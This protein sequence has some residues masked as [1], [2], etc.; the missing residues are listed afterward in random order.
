MTSVKDFGEP[1]FIFSDSTEFTFNPC[2]TGDTLVTVCDHGMIEDK[3][4]VSMGQIYQI[5]MKMLVDLYT[6]SDLPPMIV[7]YDTT[8]GKLEFDMLDAAA[9]TRKS[10]DVLELELED[11][12]KLKLT[13]DHKVW[14]ET[15]GW[16]EAKDLTQ[17][18]VILKI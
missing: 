3:K 1:G 7:S 12:S 14:T 15:R 6:S 4:L 9:L 17:T 16:I 10:A 13:P 8:T 2:V 5:P 11:G 18:D